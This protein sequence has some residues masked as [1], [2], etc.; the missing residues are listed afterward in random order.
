LVSD[1]YRNSD[2][3]FR[4]MITQL[5]NEEIQYNT[6]N[7]HVISGSNEERIDKIVNILNNTK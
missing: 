1:K 7:C 5:F 2:S 4:D 3:V 6:I